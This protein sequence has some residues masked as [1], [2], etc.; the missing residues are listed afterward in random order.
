MTVH[1]G[2][3]PKSLHGSLRIK[4]K[5]PTAY[6]ATVNSLK[7]VYVQVSNCIN[8]LWQCIVVNVLLFL[9]HQMRKRVK[10]YVEQP[11]IIT[12]EGHLDV[13]FKILQTGNS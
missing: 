11:Y 12:D 3:P 10:A 5:S 8:T 1:L 4:F 13:L 7:R 9:Q 2:T 6:Q